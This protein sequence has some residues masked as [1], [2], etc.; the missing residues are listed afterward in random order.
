MKLVT[1]LALCL[2]ALCVMLLGADAEE[3]DHEA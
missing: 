1:C 3:C 2:L